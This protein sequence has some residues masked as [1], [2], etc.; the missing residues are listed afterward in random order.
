MPVTVALHAFQKVPDVRVVTSDTGWHGWFADSALPLLEAGVR[1]HHLHNPFGLHD[2]PGRDRVMHVD[3]FEL[4][5]CDPTLHWL[6]DPVALAGAVADVHRGHGTVR[7]YVGSP[8]VVAQAPQA[9][10]L[11]RCSP[12]GKLLSSR[13]RLLA[14][15]GLCGRAGGGCTCWNR[16][17]G[18]HLAPL[19][20]AGVDAIGFDSSPDFHPGDCTD[21]LVR[22]LLGRGIEVM[23][24]PW[25]RRGRAYPPVDWIVRELHYQRIV[26]APHR[27]EAP[28]AEVTG[29]IYRIVP[30]ET[31]D[32][33][34]ELRRIND[35]RTHHHVD[36][37]ETVDDVLAAVI[38]DGDVPLVRAAQLAA[39]VA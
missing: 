11:P 39:G 38:D 15:L 36:P 17:V 29:R 12:G 5:Y 26:L 37:F 28:R 7:A 23:I 13:I 34:D 3:Q 20:Q 30:A 27:D 32:G 33:L 14:A 16:V 21:R 24:E 31:P 2:V 8:L 22:F 10:Y 1:H 19:V 35:L 18:F 4:S 6:A 25:P 9:E